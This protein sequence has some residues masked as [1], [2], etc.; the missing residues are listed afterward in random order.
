MLSNLKLAFQTFKR[1]WGDY[2]A[3]SFIFGVVC[4]I[5][6]LIGQAIFKTPLFGVITLGIALAFVVIVI[7]LIVGLKFCVFQTYD[8]PQVE[9]KSLKIGFITFFKSIKVYFLVILK[10]LIIAFVV[11]TVVSAVFLSVAMKMAAKQIPDFYQLFTNIETFEGAYEKMLEIDSV[12][13]LLTIGT[14]VSLVVSYLVFFALK[15]KRDF[16]PFIAFEMPITSD[17][18]INMNQKILKNK[19]P[20]FFISNFIVLLMFVVPAVLGYLV[21]RTMT[22]NE[23]LSPLTITLVTVAVVSVLSSPIITFKQL[24]YIHSYKELS[25]PFK[26]DFDNELKNV[27][28]EIEEL[29]KMLNKNDEK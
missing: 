11:Y 12:L 16:I 2:L 4:F 25:K 26:E 8:K 27:L 5:A 14:F 10:P 9:I 17:R 7:P 19:Y 22:A 28:K 29:Q 6:F 21:N 13:T 15:L 23:V 24:H 3:V 18:A 1:K 20:K